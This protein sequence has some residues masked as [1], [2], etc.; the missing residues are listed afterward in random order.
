[1]GT[2]GRQ[3][4]IAIFM[5]SSIFQRNRRFLQRQSFQFIIAQ[6]QFVAKLSVSVK[7]S[8]IFQVRPCYMSRQCLSAGQ[9]FE[10]G[11]FPVQ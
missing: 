8:I 5:T 10:C 2:L 11:V 3:F 1:M 6:K 4:R 7:L 9:E